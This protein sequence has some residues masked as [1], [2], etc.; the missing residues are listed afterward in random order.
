VRHVPNLL[1]L[2]FISY[3]LLRCIANILS[4]E[5]N[6]PFIIHPFQLLVHSI[7]LITRRYRAGLL[8]LPRVAS[9]FREIWYAY[10]RH[11]IQYTKKSMHVSKCIILIVF[12]Y[13]L[14]NTNILVI[15]RKMLKINLQPR[16]RCRYITTI[17]KNCLVMEFINKQLT[18]F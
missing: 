12:L 17:L 13:I 14:Y 7:Y 6:Y 15:R 5:A 18:S 3:A 11:E 9:K 1:I 4:V 2:N 16:L 10:G 8:N